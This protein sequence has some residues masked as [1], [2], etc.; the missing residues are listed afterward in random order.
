MLKHCAPRHKM[1][2]MERRMVLPGGLEEGCGVMGESY[3][4][5][6]SEFSI[7]E[8]QKVLEMDVHHSCTAR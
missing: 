8:D 2:V 3:C 5:T 4:S 6:D 7:W 1:T